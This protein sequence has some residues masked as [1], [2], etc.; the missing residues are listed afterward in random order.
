MLR[1]EQG[2]QVNDLSKK[3]C[4][5]AEKDKEKANKR[6]GE[7]TSETMVLVA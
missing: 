1:Q 5:E 3:G 6:N 4:L 2:S 7:E